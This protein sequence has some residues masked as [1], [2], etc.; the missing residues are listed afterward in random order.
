MNALFY[1]F[2]KG[3][4]ECMSIDKINRLQELIVLDISQDL[5]MF[6]I[7]NQQILNNMVSI[8][9][10]YLEICVYILT[11]TYLRRDC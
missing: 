5:V 2:L 1:V 3:I 8:S 11:C 4:I 7:L 6:C 9:I 10:Y